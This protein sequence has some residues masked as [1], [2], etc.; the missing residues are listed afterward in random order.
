M[1]RKRS[2]VPQMRGVSAFLSTAQQPHTSE[3]G[4]SLPIQKIR[5]PKKQ[6]RKYFDPNKLE[7][8]IQSIKDDGGI[9]EPILVRPLDDDS[10]D[11]LYELV[12]GD[13][14]L[15]AAEA[16]N[17]EFVPV[18][19]KRLS[20]KQAFKIALIENLKRENLNPLEET[21][22]VLTLLTEELC[23]S[24]SEIHEILTQAA[25]ASKKNTVL[26]ENVSRQMEVIEAVLSSTIAITP[27]SFRTSRLP[28]LTLPD[29]IL[30]A[31]RQGALE[32]TKA[33]EI[34]KLK[35]DKLQQEL[36]ERA[37]LESLPISEIKKEVK[38][39][40]QGT[41]DVETP[42][43]SIRLSDLSRKYKRKQISSPGKQKRIEKLLQQI[44]ALLED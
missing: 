26:S 35:D 4:C 38:A 36:L 1:T 18:V 6:P 30:E 20:E 34:A 10:E 5:R 3:S 2:T 44:E 41:T 37:I 9:L 8:L 13:R 14:R 27:E 19:I 22:G 25:T 29:R 12:A 24:V 40:R 17:H 42:S 15:R 7:E 28:L 43:I 11:G 21:E 31:L 16:L 32:Y 39:S 33:R 23:C